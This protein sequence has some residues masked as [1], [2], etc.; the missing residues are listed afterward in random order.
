MLPRSTEIQPFVAPIRPSPLVPSNFPPGGTEVTPPLP[1]STT[2]APRPQS[3]ESTTAHGRRFSSPES[4][5]Q[6]RI[7]S[8]GKPPGRTGLTRSIKTVRFR[9]ATGMVSVPNKLR[10]V[11]LYN[12]NIFPS[13]HEKNIPNNPRWLAH[14]LGRTLAIIART[15]RSY[16][17]ILS[18]S[19]SL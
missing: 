12:G 2:R 11:Y 18:C 13:T 10:L 9:H 14:G 6:V 16:G 1:E 15:M 3:P 17:V 5:V 8:I 19:P 7:R 4:F